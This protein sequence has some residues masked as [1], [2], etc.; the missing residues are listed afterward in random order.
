M[1][2]NCIGVVLP[3][4]TPKDTK[5]VAAAKPPSKRSNQFILI[6][7]LSDMYLECNKEFQIASLVEVPSQ[8]YIKVHKLKTI[9]K[10]GDKKARC[11]KICRF[12]CNGLFS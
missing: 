6:T 2:N 12:S 9:F 1:P 8:N 3:M 11:T 5:T 10:K 4:T 7:L